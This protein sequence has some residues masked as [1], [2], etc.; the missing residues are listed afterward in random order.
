MSVDCNDEEFF[1]CHVRCC[2]CKRR[3]VFGY[4]SV[5]IVHDGTFSCFRF[6]KCDQSKSLALLAL[7]I[8]CMYTG[9]LVLCGH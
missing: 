2:A 8:T 9:R 3:V 6:S 5:S 1:F 7:L 4:V